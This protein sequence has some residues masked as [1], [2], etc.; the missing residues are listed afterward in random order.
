MCLPA[1][2]FLFAPALAL[3]RKVLFFGMGLSAAIVTIVAGRNDGFFPI[4]R[5]K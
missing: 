4:F 5:K 1:Y 2:P 3:C